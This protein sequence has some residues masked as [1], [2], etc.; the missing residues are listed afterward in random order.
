MPLKIVFHPR[1]FSVFRQTAIGPLAFPSAVFGRGVSSIL[2]S[3]QQSFVLLAIT[4]FVGRDQACMEWQMLPLSN[5]M[6][7]FFHPE[8]FLSISYCSFVFLAKERSPKIL[9]EINLGLCNLQE[10]SIF[11]C[12]HSMPLIVIT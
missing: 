12:I 9:V 3:S 5:R 8:N 4:C 11:S 1:P 7:S 2:L 10:N 6:P